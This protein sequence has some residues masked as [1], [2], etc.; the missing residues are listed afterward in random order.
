MTE[1]LSTRAVPADDDQLEAA[2]RA[3]AGVLR[4]APAHQLAADFVERIVTDAEGSA[5]VG[6]GS[7]ATVA[8]DRIWAAGVGVASPERALGRVVIRAAEAA[9]ALG[10]VLDLPVDAPAAALGAAGGGDHRSD[11]TPLRSSD[12]RQR[13]QLLSVFAWLRNIGI[14]LILFAGWQLWGTG[15]TEHH[16]QSALAQQFSAR[17][18]TTRPLAAPA[19]AGHPGGPK[20]IRPVALV[21]S[22][23]VL[24]EPAEGSVVAHI[25]VPA[26]GIDQY[27]VEGTATG[28]LAKGPGHYVGTAMPGQAGN[29]AIAGHRTTHGAPFFNLGEVVP[30]DVI[31]LTTTSGQTLDYVVQSPPVA[32]SPSDVSVLDNFGDNRVTLTTCN[33]KFSASQRLVVVGVLKEPTTAVVPAGAHLADGHRPRLRLASDT[34]SG[35]GFGSLP[36]VTIPAVFLIYLGLL[37]RRARTK[38]G[39][40]AHLLVLGPLWALGLYVLFI[41]LTAFLPAAI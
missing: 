6:A 3:A 13:A 38:F 12:E 29:V 36:W 10:P 1:F 8:R 27:V 14:I 18:A 34:T 9:M 31:I 28:D 4:R 20:V 7:G 15:I 30:N 25:Q 5:G 17:A 22:S 24:P 33:P 32:V 39:H 19:T 23:V 35:W 11:A 41:A 21:P 16:D 37:H 26:A 40:P 2:V